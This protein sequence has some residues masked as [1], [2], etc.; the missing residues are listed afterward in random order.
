MSYG[1]IHV[2]WWMDFGGEG[3]VISVPPGCKDLVSK[4]IGQDAKGPL[5]EKAMVDCLVAELNAYLSTTNGPC[6]DRTFHDL[7]FACDSQTLRSPQQFASAIRIRGAEYSPAEGIGLPEH[8]FPDGIVYGVLQDQKVVSIAYAHRSGTME[9]QIADLGVET[10]PAY[11]QRGYAKAAV[12]AVVSHICER[13]GEARY[14]CAPSNHAS[15][16]TAR[17]VGFLPYA[18]SLVLSARESKG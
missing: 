18:Q 11:R 1:F 9:D 13:G 10:A 7:V 16:A 12:A 14:G 2:F 17:A 15:Q 5:P 8:C 4:I 3:S 6:I